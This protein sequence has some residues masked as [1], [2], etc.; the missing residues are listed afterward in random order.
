MG[1]ILNNLDHITVTVLAVPAT[2]KVTYY[3]DNDKSHNAIFM[4]FI[5]NNLRVKFEDSNSHGQYQVYNIFHGD[6]S[7]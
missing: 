3:L 1:C 7:G 5:T 6:R 4:C 2:T